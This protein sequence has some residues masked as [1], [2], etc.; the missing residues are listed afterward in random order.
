[1]EKIKQKIF[2]RTY[3]CTLN[4]SDSEVMKG[5]LVKAGFRIAANE[6]ESAL[7]VFN[8]CT[9]KD[10]TEK[11]FFYAL[12]KVKKP[13][14]IAGCIPQAEQKDDLRFKDFSVVGVRQLDKIVDVV[15]ETLKG[16]VVHHLGMNKNDR[17]NLPKIRKNGLV[18]I[19]PI[20][21]GCLGD[22]AYCKTRFAR[23]KLVSYEPKVIKKQFES[24]VK[25]GIKEFW[26]TSQDNGAY[27]KD[28]N[29]SLAELLN[30]LLEVGGNYKIRIGMINPN[31]FIEQFDDLIKIFKDDRMFKFLH[32]PVQVGS[33][34]ILGLMR[35][36]YTKEDFVQLIERIRKE[37]PDITISTDIIC[38]FPSETEEEFQKTLELIKRTKPGVLNISKF[39]ARPGTEAARMKPLA[40]KI[41]KKRSKELRDVFMKLALQENRKWIGWQGDVFVDEKNKDGSFTGRNFAYKPVIV[42]GKVL[43]GETINVKVFDASSYDLKSQII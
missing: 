21:N 1:M 4:Y 31:F 32:L 16:N 18:E 30:A 13:V 3:G 24:A 17:L 41:V 37:I 39:Y 5:L 34:R 35:R 8:T 40:T 12:S 22:C 20:C 11:K 26:I 14:V 42:N 27:G 29:T 28:I 33:N 38:G 25:E 2:F 6:S 9:V 7:I 23:G 19:I 15:V 10:P 43:L 36:K